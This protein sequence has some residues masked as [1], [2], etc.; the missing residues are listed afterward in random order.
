MTLVEAHHHWS[1]PE[2]L[3]F[4]K[5]SGKQEKPYVTDSAGCSLGL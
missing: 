2:V 4:W 1:G 3:L 5:S